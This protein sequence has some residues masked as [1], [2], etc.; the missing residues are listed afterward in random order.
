MN[1]LIALN[2]IFAPNVNVQVQVIVPV[3]VNISECT[4][5]STCMRMCPSLYPI[6]NQASSLTLFKQNV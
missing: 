5:L 1:K 3:R 4:N 2:I 6:Y